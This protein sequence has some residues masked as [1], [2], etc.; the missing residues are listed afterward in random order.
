MFFVE[1]SIGS[2]YGHQGNTA[3]KAREKKDAF[4]PKALEFLRVREYSHS[5]TN[6]RAEGARRKKMFRAA[7]A[8]NNII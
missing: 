7:G 1:R 2:Q 3:P 6:C 5:T 4:A 8:R